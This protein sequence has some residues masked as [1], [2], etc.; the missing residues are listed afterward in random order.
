MRLLAVNKQNYM[1]LAEEHCSR[2]YFLC[3]CIWWETQGYSAAVGIP[4][5]PE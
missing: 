5:S 3:L 4:L 1:H 2:N